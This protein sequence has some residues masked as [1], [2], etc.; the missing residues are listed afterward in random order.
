MKTRCHIMK[1]KIIII[2]L[3]LTTVLNLSAFCK[4]VAVLVGL[5]DYFY[6]P[7][8]KYAEKDAEEL[9]VILKRAGFETFLLKGENISGET[10]LER[11][12]FIAK[13][14]SYSDTLLFFFSGHGV[15][16]STEM[17]KGM[18][19]AYSDP[20]RRNAMVSHADL[21]DS[22]I[23][24][25]GKKIVVVDACYQGYDTKSQWVRTQNLIKAV[26][27]LLLSS[28]SNQQSHD[29]FNAEG[30]QINNGIA[31][32]YLRKAI[33]GYG[34]SNKDKSLSAGEL[35]EY[36]NNHAQYYAAL[37]GQYMEVYNNRSSRDK[38]IVLR[39]SIDQGEQKGTLF[40]ES[41]PSGAEIWIGGKPYG[42]TPKSF[43]LAPGTYE[44]ELRKSGCDTYQ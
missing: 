39:E 32:Y 18:L 11:I 16:G 42:Q 27:F 30:V 6:M 21:T 28:A 17:E 1:N 33:E 37:N 44:V 34:D 20:E 15:E 22:L 23:K 5:N 19:T 26:D 35:E 8:L 43:P 3:C 38:L 29:G 10:I 4:N 2:I 41:V 31:A 14:S 12:N 36:L 24:F 25:K 7:N 9:E 13:H 40:I